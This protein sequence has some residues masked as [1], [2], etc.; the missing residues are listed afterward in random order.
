M[1][2][3]ARARGLPCD[4]GISRV[5]F[6]P[7]A[8]RPS[9]AAPTASFRRTC[10]ARSRSATRAACSPPDGRWHTWRPDGTEILL[11]ADLIS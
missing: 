9:W 11:T 4:A 10:A 3:A 5:V 7:T 6:G 8:P 2:S 1:I